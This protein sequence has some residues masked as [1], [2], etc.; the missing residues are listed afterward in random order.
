M[1]PNARIKHLCGI[2]SNEKGMKQPG[3]RINLNVVLTV[4]VKDVIDID[5]LAV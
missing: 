1:Q 5:Y 2:Q 4:S 3:C